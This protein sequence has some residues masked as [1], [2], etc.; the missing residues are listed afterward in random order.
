MPDTANLALPYMEA[1]QAQKHVTHNEALAQLD[2]CVQLSVLARGGEAPPASP[3]RGARYIVAPF[4]LDAFA[5]H[6][7]EIAYRDE[8]GWRFVKPQSGWIAWVEA[9]DAPFLFHAGAWK[10]FDVKC[11]SPNVMRLAGL[12]AVVTLAAARAIVAAD[13]GKVLNVNAG[14]AVALT[15]SAGLPVGF[16]CSVVQSGAGQVSFAAAPGVTLAHPANAFRTAARNA[17]VDLLCVAAGVIVVS[18]ALVV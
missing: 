3:A 12:G 7:G 18:G 17:R 13:D 6:A 5:G 15:L 2:A 11:L 10:R 8:A 1:A 16:A 14:A 9:E 4:G